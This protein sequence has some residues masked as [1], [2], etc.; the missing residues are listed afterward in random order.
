MGDY[1]DLLEKINE[2]LTANKS[3]LENAI[4][5]KITEVNTNMANLNQSINQNINSKFETVNLKMEAISTE[6]EKIREELLVQ[7]SRMDKIEETRNEG[8]IDR[9]LNIIIYGLRG[10]YYNVVL[11][12]IINILNGIG[13]EVSKYCVKSMYKIGKKRWNEDGPI[14]VT[15]ISNVL[16]NDIMKNKYKLKNHLEGIKIREDLSE[17][18]R[19][20]RKLLA[21][22]SLEAK[23]KG[24]KVYMRGSKLII[25]GKAW[26]LQELQN[27]PS[28]D[29]PGH[30]EEESMYCSDTNESQTKENM[31]MQVVDRESINSRKR[32]LQISPLSS[33]NV[34]GTPIKKGKGE[35]KL[36]KGFQKSITD[37][38]SSVGISGNRTP[39]PLPLPPPI[40]PK[41]P[42]PPQVQTNNPLFN[43]NNK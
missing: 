31:V 21:K 8:I 36:N 16:R 15:F 33:E 28:N 41:P 19:E 35:K 40:I 39:P 5:S 10:E 18:D 42:P 38:W 13:V 12:H 22:F 1:Q 2:S 20:S 4:Q 17:E 9:N 27:Q 11:A 43:S 32:T 23:N 3:A 7:K 34:I 26:S 25:Q 24:K 30:E 14:R 37:M 6:N 29:N